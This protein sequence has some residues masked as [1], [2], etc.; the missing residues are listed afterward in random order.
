MSEKMTR[1]DLEA[2]FNWNAEFSTAFKDIRPEKV[3]KTPAMKV[4]ETPV[5]LMKSLTQMA[6]LV[7]ARS[8]SKR[9]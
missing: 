3:G 6:K 7:A 1:E 5:E 4:V 2:I 8:E 9:D